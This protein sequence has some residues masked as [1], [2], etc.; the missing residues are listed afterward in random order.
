MPSREDW[1]VGG[2][3]VAVLAALGITLFVLSRKKPSSGYT[4]RKIERQPVL[5][6]LERVKLVR[7]RE[8]NL[9][10]LIIHREVRE[11]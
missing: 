11:P 7:D 3:V 6:N 8:G 10:E 5:T 9:S 4:L 1:I 2:I